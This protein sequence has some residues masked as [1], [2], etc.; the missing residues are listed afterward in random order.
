MSSVQGKD[1]W[2]A[3]LG[4]YCAENDAAYYS[5]FVESLAGIDPHHPMLD[6][7]NALD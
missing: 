2:T 1:T 4:A 7:V 3:Y 5:Q 6:I